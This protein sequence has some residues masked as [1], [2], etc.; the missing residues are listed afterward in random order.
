MV[1]R[2]LFVLLS[3]STRLL[4]RHS[5]VP[6]GGGAEDEVIEDGGVRCDTDAGA[7]HDSDLELVP[8]LK[9][10]V[11]SSVKYLRVL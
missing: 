5:R 7:D 4:A 10:R 1:A 6:I 3:R 9:G 11:V 2:I 8:V